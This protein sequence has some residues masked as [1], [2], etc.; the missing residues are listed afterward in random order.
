LFILFISNFLYL[1]LF[2][3]FSISTTING[4]IIYEIEL[5]LK[6]I[7]VIIEYPSYNNQM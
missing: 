5:F 7:E 2:K 1:I 4:E 6:R 3:V